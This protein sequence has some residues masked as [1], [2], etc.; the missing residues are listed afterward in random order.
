VKNKKSLATDLSITTEMSTCLLS[1]FPTIFPLR[2]LKNNQFSKNQLRDL[3]TQGS[4]DIIEV[5][6]SD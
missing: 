6:N 2:N 1:F 3:V 4:G 5:G